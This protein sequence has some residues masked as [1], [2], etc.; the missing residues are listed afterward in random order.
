MVKYILKRIL[1]MSALFLVFLSATWFLVELQPG[2]PSQVYVGNPE[3]PPE[4]KQIIIERFGL[5]QPR[6]V[7]YLRYITNFLH[8]DMGQSSS[9]FPRQVWDLLKERIPR[10]LFLFI[11][12]TLMSYF[13]GFLTGKIVAWRRGSKTEQGMTIAGVALYTVFY[14][15]FALVMIWLFSYTLGEVTGLRIFPLGGFIDQGEWPSTLG[16]QPNTIFIQLL[17]SALLVVLCRVVGGILSR[18][19]E[20]RAAAKWVRR[21]SFL[22][23]LALAVMFWWSSQYTAQAVDLLQHLALPTF[24]LTMVA[25][26]G[27]MLLTRSSMLETLKEDYILTA[28]AK[29]VSESDIRDNHAARNALLPVTTSLVLALA[30]VIGGGVVTETVFSWPGLGQLELEA[31]LRGDIPLALGGLTMI[32]VLALLGHLIVDILYMYLDPR[33]RYS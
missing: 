13:V 27:A 30:F 29:G 16:V 32:G 9:Q 18:R 14:P 3:I 8:G 6:G 12:A 20:S 23:P 15:W 26:G 22:V 33:I 7:R 4:A 28:R 2:D 1:V 21:G 31:I 19:V 25:F 5:D 17:F 24:T 11:A 10:T